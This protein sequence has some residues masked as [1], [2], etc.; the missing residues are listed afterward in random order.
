MYRQNC[1]GLVWCLGKA[2]HK[3]LLKW[4]ELPGSSTS[5]PYFTQVEP[6]QGM[7]LRSNLTWLHLVRNVQPEY[8]SLKWEGLISHLRDLW[9]REQ[10]PGFP[11]GLVGGWGRYCIAPSY[12]VSGQRQQ[13]QITS[14]HLTWGGRKPIQCVR[15]HLLWLPHPFKSSWPKRGYALIT[16]SNARRYN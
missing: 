7:T 9:F 10:D 3:H 2:F 8:T 4:A 6:E 11:P 14:L 5:I 1:L 13:A 16:F 15:N 12:V